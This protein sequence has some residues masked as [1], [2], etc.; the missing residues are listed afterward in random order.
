MPGERP[1][2]IQKMGV[3]K[4]NGTP[5]SSILI[6][7]SLINHPFWGIPIF[8]N[9]H[10]IKFYSLSR[11]HGSSEWV[12]TQVSSTIGPFF[13]VMIVGERE[14]GYSSTSKT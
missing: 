13:I 1:F 2:L 3:S 5:K 6:G 8:G 14:K 12:P 4:N 10:I 7:F 9:T 11:S